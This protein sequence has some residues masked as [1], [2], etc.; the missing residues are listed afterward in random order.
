MPDKLTELF[1]LWRE[2]LPE[3]QRTLYGAFQAGLTSGAVSMR[4][5]AMQVMQ[6]CPGSWSEE[7]V[8]QVVNMV[9]QLSDIPQE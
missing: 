9:G 2:S 1:E 6:E 3:G 8:N 7:Q 4:Q 5:R